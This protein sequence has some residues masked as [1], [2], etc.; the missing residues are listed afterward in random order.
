[1]IDLR[2]LRQFIAVAEELHFHKAAARLNMSQPPLTAAVRKLEEEVGTELIERR[3]RTIRLTAAGA[4]LLDE[5][6]RTIRQADRAVDAAREAA[7]GQTGTVRVSYVG[8]ALYGRLPRLIRRFRQDSPTV[9]LELREA[10][11]AQQVSMLRS[12][13]TDIAVVIPPAGDSADM[14]IELFDADRLAIAMPRDHRLARSGRIALA[15]LADEPFVFWP[16]IEGRGFHVQ[17]IRLCT[18]AG[19]TPRV[20]Q[21]A[22]GMHA[23]LS[24]VAVGA[25]VSLVPASMSTFRADEVVYHPIRAK[26]AR[27]D[28]A[29]CWNDPVRAPAVRRF[30]DLAKALPR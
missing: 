4:A 13:L 19:F 10:T 18:Q 21:E 12:R 9:R 23:V 6:R 15:A 22:Y 29:L 27:F 5:A 7:Q 25:G 8:S 1:M 16:A 20:V 28:R 3:N 26:E 11:T 2:Q 14:T 24:L 17:A 30:I